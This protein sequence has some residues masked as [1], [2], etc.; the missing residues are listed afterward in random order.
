M[1]NFYNTK[2]APTLNL[3]HLRNLNTS[4]RIHCETYG[5]CINYNAKLSLY[6]RDQYIKQQGLELWTDYQSMVD[7]IIEMDRQSSAFT[8]DEVRAIASRH[9]RQRFEVENDISVLTQMKLIFQEEN[10]Q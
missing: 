10:Q 7:E 9:G 1:E 5:L 3:H 8:D 4:W 6:F 2:N